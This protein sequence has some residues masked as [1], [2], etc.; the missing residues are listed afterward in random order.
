[1]VSGLEILFSVRKSC[2]CCASN[3]WRHII[4]MGRTQRK[5]REIEG[6]PL[7]KK[8]LKLVIHRVGYAN[9]EWCSPE[10]CQ[11]TTDGPSSN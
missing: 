5:E 6:K 10:L 3:Y 4:K 11:Y 9:R 8:H 7:G 1:M 2:D